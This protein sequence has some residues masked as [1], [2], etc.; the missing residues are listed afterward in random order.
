[1]G[2]FTDKTAMGRS[3]RTPLV[4][5]HML[6]DGVASLLRPIRKVRRFIM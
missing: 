6:R 4:F 3:K 5:R 1:L 2:S